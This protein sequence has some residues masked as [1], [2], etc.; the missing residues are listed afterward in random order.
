MHWARAR[1]LLLL[2]FTLVNVALLDRAWRPGGPGAM[3]DMGLAAF[4]LREVRSRLGQQGFNL[5]ARVPTTG[6]VLPFLRLASPTP[7]LQQRVVLRFLEM[8]AAREPPRPDNT[9]ETGEVFAAGNG[10][11]VFRPDRPWGHDVRVENRTVVRELADDFLSQSQLAKVADL[12]WFRS[13]PLDQG[14]RQ[15]VEY[16]L[17]YGGFPVYAGYLHVTVGPAGVEE[18]VAYLPAA[19]E[20]RGD[21]KSVIS[22]T[23]AL[24]RLAGHLSVGQSAAEG[25]RR[26][27]TDL[28]LG[29]YAPYP[30]KGTPAWEVVPVWRVNMDSQDIYY[31]NALTGELEAL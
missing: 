24:L 16:T 18:A 31:V 28:E 6:K 2:T 12:R 14:G 9:S 8:L 22:G 7:E 11:V 19:G 25:K 5:T 30:G 20:F 27:F 29:Y 15:L 17:F 3:S 4:E 10:L 13:V 23:Q 21:P 26:T 1:L